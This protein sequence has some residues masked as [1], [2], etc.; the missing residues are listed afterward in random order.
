MMPTLSTVKPPDDLMAYLVQSLVPVEEFGL[1]GSVL[2]STKEDVSSDATVEDLK[3]D[4]GAKAS[5]KKRF[6]DVYFKC[7]M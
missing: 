1:L 2:N 7:Q 4:L 3:D 6:E 5:E